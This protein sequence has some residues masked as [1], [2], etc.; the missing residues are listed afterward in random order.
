MASSRLHLCGLVGDSGMMGT[1]NIANIA[2]RGVGVNSEGLLPFPPPDRGGVLGGA[3]LLVR[4]ADFGDPKLGK[5]DG[6][7]DVGRNGLELCGVG[8]C[9]W[10]E[11]VAAMKRRRLG[12]CV[13]AGRRD[14]A[15]GSD[16]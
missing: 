15:D 3:G 1:F 10:L 13:F 11:V 8:R 16:R 9:R 7:C 2:E 4:G 12:E 5:P 6:E 14:E